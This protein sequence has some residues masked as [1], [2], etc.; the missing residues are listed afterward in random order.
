MHPFSQILMS[1]VITILLIPMLSTGAAGQSKMPQQGSPATR[2]LQPLPEYMKPFVERFLRSACKAPTGSGTTHNINVTASQVWTEAGS[3]HVLPFDINISAPVTIE[4]CAVVRI[5]VNKTITILPGGVFIAA[6]KNRL[7]VTIEPLVVG[8]PWMQIRALGGVLSLTHAVVV[9]GGA[10]LP[11]LVAQSAALRVQNGSLHVDEVEIVD[12]QSQGVLLNGTG[13][14]DASSHDLWVHGSVG[15]PVNVFANLV[16]SIPSG[17]YRGNGRDAIGIGLAGGPVRVT[18][19]MFNHGVPYHVGTG[20]DGGRMDINSQVSGS[21]AVL[22]IQS[23]V[24]ILFPPGA[25]CL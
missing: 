19:T 25:C 12:S 24:T 14:F 17:Q 10:S 13:G 5:A 20:Q 2:P 9:G 11:A 18:Q 7:P 23:G 1:T 22:T 16:G 21:V 3:P 15:F 6:G 4:A 8:K